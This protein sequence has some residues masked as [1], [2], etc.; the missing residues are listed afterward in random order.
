MIC[1]VSVCGWG[2]LRSWGWLFGAEGS[3]PQLVP[4]VLLT[5]GGAIKGFMLLDF[6]AATSYLS[7]DKCRVSRSTHHPAWSGANAGRTLTRVCGPLGRGPKLQLVREIAALRVC[8]L[9]KKTSLMG[10]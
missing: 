5:E 9:P 3:L 7:S 10:A 1:E 4:R 2:C 8:F 6:R